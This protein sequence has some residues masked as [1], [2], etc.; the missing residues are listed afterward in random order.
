M[1]LIHPP[2]AKI[3]EPPGGLPRLAGALRGHGFDCTVLDGSLEA[4]LFLLDQPVVAHDT[5]SRRAIKNR[6][7]NLEAFSSPNLYRNRDRYR[8]CVADLNRVLDL[9]GRLADISL[10]LSNYTDRR[11]SPLRSSDLLQAAHEHEK[12]LL[13]PWFSKRL[14][15]LIAEQRPTTVGISLNYLSQALTSF[16]LL[17]FLKAHYPGLTLILGGGLV[18]S[19]MRNPGWRNRFSGL[20]DHLI[21]GPGEAPLLRLLGFKGTIHH[22]TPDYAPL[23]D[24]PY[25]APGLILPYA[26][27]SGCYWNRCSFCPE[28]AEDNPYHALAVD[29][30]MEDLVQLTGKH[31]PTLIHFLDNAI[32]VPLLDRLAS[33]KKIAHWYG[34]VRFSQRLADPA[35]CRSLQQ[36][37]CLM[38]KLGLESG[39]QQVLDQMDKG[40][41]LPL[42]AKI[43]SNLKEVGISTYIYLLFGTPTESIH[44]AR[45]TMNFVNRHHE[46]MTY[47][48]LAVFNLPLASAETD[49]VQIQPFSEGDLSLYC[50]FVHPLGFHRRAVR[51]FLDREFRREAAISRII[52]RDPPFFTSNHAPLFHLEM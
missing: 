8:R 31:Q 1:L 32:P 43:L 2:I 18:T 22:T 3:C 50:D 6:T 14:A 7:R 49:R 19:W 41:Q 52:R 9:N 35:Y 46:A 48:N 36:S 37:G 40:I 5:W 38:L 47:L 10:S 44:E 27:S 21:S 12:N 26:A 30:V 45:K 39:D 4:Q 25:L 42:V 51:H 20:V 11:L 33:R 34:F 17:G 16:S 24:L 28:K 29:R 15:D 13:F 23:T